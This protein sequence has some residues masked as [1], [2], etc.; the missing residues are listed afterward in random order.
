MSGTLRTKACQIAPLSTI[1]NALNDITTDLNTITLDG[2]QTPASLNWTLTSAVS[3]N[4]AGFTVGYGGNGITLS[5]VAA[6]I[7]TDLYL[8]RD[9]P[10][11]AIFRFD[12]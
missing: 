1:Y 10:D 2:G 12:R 3:I 4:D 8:G 9:N 6:E 5:V 11:A 7:I